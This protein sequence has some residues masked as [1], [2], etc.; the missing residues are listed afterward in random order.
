MCSKQEK[1]RHKP[2]P[3]GKQKF[4]GKNKTEIIE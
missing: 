4:R 2:S 3:L 1:C